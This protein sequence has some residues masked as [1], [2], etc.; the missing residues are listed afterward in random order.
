MSRTKK[1]T[2]CSSGRS[3]NNL[4]DKTKRVWARQT[5]LH[6]NSIF[7]DGRSTFTFTTS[8]CWYWIDMCNGDGTRLADDRAEKKTLAEQD[9]VLGSRDAETIK[10]QE[11]NFS[12]AEQNFHRRFSY[13]I[14]EKF[15]ANPTYSVYKCAY[16]DYFTQNSTKFVLFPTFIQ[17][18]LFAKTSIN[19]ENLF[20]CSENK[21]DCTVHA[22]QAWSPSRVDYEMFS[23]VFACT[24]TC[25]RDFWRTW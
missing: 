11:K 10:E 12:S 3:N 7:N 14:Y 18:K 6:V 8:I 24:C 25:C 1:K 5:H 4:H 21:A 13:R 23:Q 16:E 15:W 20:C 19:W 22:T 17:F 2:N 9:A